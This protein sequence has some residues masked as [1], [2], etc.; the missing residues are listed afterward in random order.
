VGEEKVSIRVRGRDG[1]GPGM[2][3]AEQKKGW[4]I[5][6]SG[7][8]KP[9]PRTWKK[10]E[11]G[12]NVPGSRPEGRKAHIPSHPV[13]RKGEGVVLPVRGRGCDRK[14]PERGG[15]QEEEGGTRL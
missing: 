15:N 7:R 5:N 14:N 1:V 12:L 2:F 11:P 10:D 13:R 9:G 3:D 6:L 8:R 4:R